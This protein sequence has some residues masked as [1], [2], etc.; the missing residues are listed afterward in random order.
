MSPNSEINQTGLDWLLEE[1]HPGVRF[2]ALRDLC[3]LDQDEARDLLLIAADDSGRQRLQ[4]AW[5]SK[6]SLDLA[7][8]DVVDLGE[9]SALGFAT[10]SASDGPLLMIATSKAIYRVQIGQ[11]RGSL[12][13][14]AVD[15]IPGARA[16]ALGDMTGDGL[17][18]LAVALQGGVRLFAEVPRLP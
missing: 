12:N 9:E 11:D 7:S 10:A 4:V 16:I 5:N 14:E 13:P 18:D 15:G 8:V 3:D 6:G 2:L 1:Q 17:A